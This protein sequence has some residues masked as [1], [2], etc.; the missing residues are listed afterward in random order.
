MY[1]DQKL[2]TNEQKHFEA[3]LNI[4]R[5]N[6]QQD[7]KSSHEDVVSEEE[8]IPSISKTPRREGGRSRIL[9][10]RRPRQIFNES[11][12]FHDSVYLEP[13]NVEEATHYPQ[14]NL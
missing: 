6:T 10:S 3:P 2:S 11:N 4:L 8:G 13:W 12:V 1:E 7:G 5:S 9:K 14:K